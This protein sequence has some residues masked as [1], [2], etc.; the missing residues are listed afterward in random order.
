MSDKTAKSTTRKGHV[1]RLP[2]EIREQLNALIRDGATAA[3]L[4]A[5]LEQ[6]GHKKLN[7]QNW[8]NWRQGGYQDWL[9]EQAYLDTVRQKHETIRRELE[10][11]GLSVLD[12]AIF[13]VATSLADSDIDPTKAAAAI[14]TLK[15]AVTGDKRVQIYER[16]AALAEQALNLEREKFAAAQAR[17]A[18]ADKAEGVV[19]DGALTPEQKQQRIK[20]I[21]GLA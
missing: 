1:A 4:N 21:F 12:K 2:Y 15:T 9:K 8:T 13:E 18:Q 3:E 17:A 5:F 14:A 11:G 20:E 6:N 7:D 16:R 19:K 10:A